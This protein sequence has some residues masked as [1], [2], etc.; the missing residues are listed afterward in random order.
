MRPWGSIRAGGYLGAM[1]LG[2]AA[3]IALLPGSGK[4]QAVPQTGQ[5][6][7]AAAKAPLPDEVPRGATVAGRARPDY[8]AAGIRLGGFMLYPD[9][10]VQESY[11]S[12]IYA[13][14]NNRQDDFITTVTPSLDLR[15][16][17]NNH[18][19]HVHADTTMARYADHSSENYTDYTLGADGRVD[20]LRDLRLY[21]GA[22]YARRHE[23][24]SSPD[25]QGGT[26]PTEY[27]LYT[28]NAAIEKEFNRIALRLDGKGERYVFSDVQNSSGAT[29]DQSGR[30]RD[31]GELALRTSYELAPLRTVYVQ[32]SVNTRDY[33]Q[34]RDAS[35]YA[36][37]SNGY[38]LV[39]GTEYDLT[40]I[41]FI[42]VFAGWRQQ[43]YDDARLKTM[44]GWT[45]GAKLTWNV[46]RLT[47]VTGG[48]TRDIEETTLAGASGYFA[49]RTDLRVDHELLRNLLLNAQLGYEQDS[50]DGIGR[51]DDYYTAGFGAKYLINRN[52]AL[53][54]G[55]A[56][57]TRNSSAA[58]S[59]FDENVVF[60]RLSSHI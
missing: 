23:S 21:G 33:D 24:R 19:L 30:D 43:D 36:R 42:D 14:E 55:Y 13:T 41:T 37:S 35:G 56:Y 20:V 52:F 27:S 29:L 5:A 10:A 53:S 26:E 49:T 47:T 39:V 11:N 51:D 46:T 58:S 4:A 15:S 7:T 25:N 8:D 54:G 40:G 34:S 38:G 57:R 2:F 59:D 1:T 16:N 17:W 48:L 45:A 28:A 60:L 31:Q 44:S 9:L 3:A 50:F 18:A 22:S 32:G 6:G 12:N